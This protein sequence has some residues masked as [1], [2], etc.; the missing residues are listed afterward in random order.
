MWC[1]NYVEM[2]CENMTYLFPSNCGPY[3]IQRLKTHGPIVLRG[4]VVFI[5]IPRGAVA[6]TLG[7]VL[8]LS[9]LS[10]ETAQTFPDASKLEPFWQ[11]WVE[12]AHFHG[13]RK[14][15]PRSTGADCPVQIPWGC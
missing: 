3:R 5:K 13:S 6:S 12:T 2:Q 10:V 7:D 15:S 11:N 1:T 9:L 4:Q 14:L 8:E